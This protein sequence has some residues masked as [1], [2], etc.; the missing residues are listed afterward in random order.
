MTS[1]LARLI[2]GSLPLDDWV[3]LVRATVPAP[4][5]DGQEE[6]RFR[7]L[8][9]RVRAWWARVRGARA[10]DALRRPR[11]LSAQRPSASV[12]TTAS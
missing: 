3:A 12:V 6:R 5:G 2:A 11:A 4:A 10:P 7:R 1:A 8:G 9:D